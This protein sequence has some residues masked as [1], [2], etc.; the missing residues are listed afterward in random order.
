MRSIWL[1]LVAGAIAALAVGCGSAPSTDDQRSIV[2]VVND[3]ETQGMHQLQDGAQCPEGLA[4]FCSSATDPDT[5]CTCVDAT[6]AL[7]E[8]RRLFNTR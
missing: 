7:A 5:N 2:E 6:E 8:M 1:A 3:F 4:K